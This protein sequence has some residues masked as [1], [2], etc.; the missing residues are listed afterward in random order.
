MPVCLA[1]GGC[2]VLS[3]NFS[4]ASVPQVDEAAQVV[5]QSTGTGL[6]QINSDPFTNPDSNHKTQVEPGSYSFGNTI[7]TAMQ[8]GRY[9][10]GGASDISFS[11]STDGGKTWTTG[12]LPATVNS[13]PAGPYA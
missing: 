2:L 1:V 11:T 6:L 7:V 4:Y 13:T 12:T 8:S 5:A 10:D 3:L 9:F